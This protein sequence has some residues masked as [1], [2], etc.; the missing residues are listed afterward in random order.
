MLISLRLLWGHCDLMLDVSSAN[1]HTRFIF[2]QLVCVS[3]LCQT[4][5]SVCLSV[6][7]VSV[8]R[9]CLRLCVSVCWRWICCPAEWKQKKTHLSF[10]SSSF[11][12]Q[13]LAVHSNL[14]ILFPFFPGNWISAGHTHTHTHLFT[15]H[16]LP[17]DLTHKSRL[18]VQTHS[19]SSQ[20]LVFYL[21]DCIGHTHTH[22]HTLVCGLT[23]W[24]SRLIDR[25]TDCVQGL[26]SK[27]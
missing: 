17:I 25:W 26:I 14:S 27:V 3:A 18:S 6:W 5:L 9:M 22:T 21:L 24:L 10:C 15:E 19:G 23:L 11:S 8:T 7:K 20:W 1:T 12:R 13:L 4:S 16:T 2:H